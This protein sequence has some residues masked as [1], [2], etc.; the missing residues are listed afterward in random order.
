MSRTLPANTPIFRQGEVLE[1]H[2]IVLQGWVALTVVLEDG[3]Y[4]IVD[5]ALPGGLLGLTPGREAPV[6]HAAL[7]LTA[8]TGVSVMRNEIDAVLD[9]H[10]AIARHLTDLAMSQ[11]DRMQDHLLNI[12]GRNAFQRVAH[13]L[14]E[15]Y[16]R[17]K[18]RL[19]EANDPAIQL[20]LT[21]AQLGATTALTSVHISRVLAAMRR[22]AVA[23]LRRGILRVFDP[24]ALVQAAGGWDD[25][26]R[27]MAR[28]DVASV[29]VGEFS[30][31]AVASPSRHGDTGPAG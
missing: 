18:G 31:E 6:S 15:L 16:V 28:R 2:F 4:Q 7:C 23:D 25:T 5:F 8:V 13:L 21:H 11:R 27:F 20:P 29:D 1:S 30:E 24:A 19:P 9:R 26:H 17:I 12:A 10:P 14:V 22:E 3:S